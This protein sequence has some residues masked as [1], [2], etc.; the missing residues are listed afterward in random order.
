MIVQLL[1]K[2][3]SHSLAH[4]SGLL[5]VIQKGYALFSGNHGNYIGWETLQHSHL[6]FERTTLTR[7]CR[8]NWKIAATP[9]KIRAYE[10]ALEAYQDKDGMVKSPV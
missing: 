10:T 3:L 5:G 8:P 1:F 4:A 7:F 6:C 2:V 9:S